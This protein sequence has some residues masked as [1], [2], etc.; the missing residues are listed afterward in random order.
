MFPDERKKAMWMVR[1]KVLVEA[2]FLCE[3]ASLFSLSPAEK[4]GRGG[5]KGLES[6]LPAGKRACV[7]THF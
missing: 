7:Q 1:Q 4:R 6:A 3:G 5:G 2:K